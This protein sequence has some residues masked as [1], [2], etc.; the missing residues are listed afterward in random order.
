[1]EKSRNPRPK[2]GALPG[3]TRRTTGVFSGDYEPPQ[4]WHTFY[5]QLAHMEGTKR[6]GNTVQIGN[7]SNAELAWVAR[8]IA[9]ELERRKTK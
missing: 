2:G 5:I 9:A 1:M 4:E 3:R 7:L 6:T 8:T